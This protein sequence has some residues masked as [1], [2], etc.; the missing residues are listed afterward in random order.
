MLILA[1]I[2][3][4]LSIGENGLFKTAKYAAVK[5]E[6]EKAREKLEVA[7]A[8]LQAH[9]Y[10]NID[11]DE[12]DYID[13]Y[14]SKEKMK[15]IGDIV[16]V[17][18]W[19]FTIDRSVPQ[20]GVLIGRENNTWKKL[21]DE[22]FSLD[23]IVNNENL[24]NKVI[25]KQEDIE[26][27]INNTKE[28]M[29]I[30]VNSQTAMDIIL[31]EENIY[32]YIFGNTE[33]NIPVNT[34]WINEILKNNKAIECLDNSKPT[35]VPNMTGYKTPYGEAKAKSEYSGGKN[36]AWK[37]FN[38]ATSTEN[39]CWHS[40][41]NDELPQWIQYKFEK[42]V[43]IYKFYMQNRNQT[44]TWVNAPEK[45]ILKASNDEENWEV[46]GEYTN[47]RFSKLQG[48]TYIVNNISKRYLYYRI[49]IIT[50]KRT[51]GKTSSHFGAIGRL[52]FYGK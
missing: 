24:F 16:V 26:H 49:E 37:A 50:A 6:E 44:T 9:K 46:L 43:L 10:T 2:V 25:D 27:M 42:P 4:S 47:K 32:K 48:S 23:E 20:I 22:G 18:G 29:P 11:Y 39:D 45:F 33:E 12:N 17:D 34:N 14:L 52:Q 40:Y 36:P 3:I 30:V 31:K 21:K 5:T 41:D 13:N 8:D 1:G 28:I 7:L 51:D 19:E 15:V 35:T 38:S